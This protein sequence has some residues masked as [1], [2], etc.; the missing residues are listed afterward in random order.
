[1]TIV[2]TRAITG[3][4]DTAVA[5]YRCTPQP[6][7]QVQE[8]LTSHVAPSCSTSQTMPINPAEGHRA[9]LRAARCRPILPTF[10]PQMIKARLPWSGNRACD[11]LLLE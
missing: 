2:E 11:L 6:R 7:Q 9:G 1:M 3:G 10:C 5:T 8:L 4:V